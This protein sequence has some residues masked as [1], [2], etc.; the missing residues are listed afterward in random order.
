MSRILILMCIV[1]ASTTFAEELRI[2][3]GEEERADLSLTIYNN[4]FALIRE[5]KNIVLPRGR[6][7]L[8]Y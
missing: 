2:V 8:E 1:I 6:F 5:R 3:V 4:N 7:E